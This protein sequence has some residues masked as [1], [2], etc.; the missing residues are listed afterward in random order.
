MKKLLLAAA[1]ALAAS[2]ASAQEVVV[3]LGTLAP[4]GSTWHKLLQEMSEKW[5]QA[6]G[7]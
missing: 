5:S 3:K 1:L 6:S 7:A 4:N 2:T